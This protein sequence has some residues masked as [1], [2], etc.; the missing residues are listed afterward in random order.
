M[1][2]KPILLVH[3]DDDVRAVLAAELSGL[4]EV[5]QAADGEQGLAMALDRLPRLVVADIHMPGLDGFQL[6]RVLA[7]AA[8]GVGI[9]V[10]LVS[11]SYR[12]P[13][14]ARLAGDLGAAAYV[15]APY[16]PGAVREA[17]QRV[18]AAHPTRPVTPPSARVL[19]VE[20]E[21]DVAMVVRTTLEARGYVVE[22]VADGNAVLAAA[23]LFHPDMVLLDYN[24]PGRTGL[25]ALR[26]LRRHGIDAGAVVLSAFVD[27]ALTVEFVRAGAEDVLAKPFEPGALLAAIGRGLE[28]RAMHLRAAQFR[29]RLEAVRRSEARCQSLID[30]S[31]D[32]IVF[33]DIDGRIRKSSPA[34]AALTGRLPAKLD[35]ARVLELFA[36]D[37]RER[38]QQAMDGVENGDEFECD[39]LG[40]DGALIPLSV[41]VQAL[42]EDGRLLGRWLVGRDLRRQRALSVRLAQAEK[43]AGVMRLVTGISHEFSGLVAGIVGHV[44]LGLQSPDVLGER[45]ALFRIQDAGT[46]AA[47]LLEAMRAV[48]YASGGGEPIDAAAL[49]R[50]AAATEAPKFAEAGARLGVALARP[51]QPGRRAPP[52]VAGRAPPAS[53]PGAARP[54]AAPVRAPRAG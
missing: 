30:C 45:E 16:R 10:I 35:G 18:L 21:P 39:L 28:R 34:T 19:V 54:R 31:R 32:V 1:K 36:P 14:A 17:A 49:A 50:Q 37:S 47:D 22:H 15:D 38:L 2:E 43:R 11:A 26:E 42:R 8:D 23:A 53:G 9:P 44:S 52:A 25:D 48:V 3:D 41:R 20:D 7:R 33:V 13:A 6:C 46:R 4:G 29:E 51:A 24:L 40:G 5:V 12:D 27:V